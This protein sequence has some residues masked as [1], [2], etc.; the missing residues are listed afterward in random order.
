VVVDYVVVLY[1]KSS[2]RRREEEVSVECNR[3]R[4]EDRSKELEESFEGN[5]RINFWG[6]TVL[7]DI[8]RRKSGTTEDTEKTIVP[9]RKGQERSFPEKEIRGEREE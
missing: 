1:D 7:E 8:V 4:E 5:G 9:E 3:I 6:K 2:W